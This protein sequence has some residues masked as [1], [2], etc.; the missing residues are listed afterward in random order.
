MEFGIHKCLRPFLAHTWWPMSIH[1][2]RDCVWPRIF[3]LSCKYI[4][5]LLECEHLDGE[6]MWP[7]REKTQ[8][9]WECFFPLQKLAWNFNFLSLI[10]KNIS[11]IQDSHKYSK[12]HKLVKI[13]VNIDSRL[14]SGHSKC[15]S[16]TQSA[17]LYLHK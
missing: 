11:L 15:N 13:C 3:D 14:W 16:F 7:T 5:P 12:F 2:L 4:G 17:D 8:T 1:W 10:F 9:Y 6:S